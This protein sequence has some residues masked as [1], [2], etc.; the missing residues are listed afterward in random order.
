MHCS[1]GNNL[2]R[3]GQSADDIHILFFLGITVMFCMQ[4]LSQLRSAS[5]ILAT[6]A[7]PYCVYYIVS[8][9]R[10]SR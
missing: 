3:P 1:L 2:I 6:V 8:A 9:N 4:C 5:Y 7:L 10:W